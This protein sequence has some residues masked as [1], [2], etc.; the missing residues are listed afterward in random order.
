M[1]KFFDQ[2]LTVRGFL[3]TGAVFSAFA[4]VLE[5]YDL[6]TLPPDEIGFS[7]LVTMVVAAITLVAML[8]LLLKR[9]GLPP[10]DR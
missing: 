3:K 8:F 1:P 4:I 7:D 5:T 2:L 10:P 6:L 9:V